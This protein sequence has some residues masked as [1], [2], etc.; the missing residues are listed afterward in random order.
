M[1]NNMY[2][3]KWNIYFFFLL[4]KGAIVMCKRNGS[5]QRQSRFICLK[6]LQMNQVGAGIQR[7]GHRRNKY[8][9]KNLLCIRCQCETYNME[10]R[11]CDAYED[12][13]A[14]AIRERSKYYE[15]ENSNVDDRKAG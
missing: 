7:G 2:E 8:H 15:T 9:V 3:K 11:D 12:V 5:P 14:Q 6:C 10:I 13:Y 1:S 4:Q